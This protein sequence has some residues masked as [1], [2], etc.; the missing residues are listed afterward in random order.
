MRTRR[1]VLAP[2]R[3]SATISAWRSP[4]APPR[5]FSDAH[6]DRRGEDPRAD[7]RGA[8]RRHDGA[9]R[10]D[11]GRRLL[12]L[13]V[14][15]RL[16]HPGGRGRPRAR[17]RGRQRSSSIRSASRTSRARR[18]TSSTG[19]RSPASRSTTR[20]PRRRAAAGTPSRW[21]R[22]PRMPRTRTSAAAAPAAPTEL[23][24]ARA[25]PFH[26]AGAEPAAHHRG[27]DRKGARHPV[28]CRCTPR[29]RIQRSLSW[30]GGLRAS[31]SCGGRGLGAGGVLRGGRAARERGADRRG[32]PVRPAADAVGARAARRRS[33]PSEHQ[34]RL[35]GLRADRAAAGFPVLRQRRGRPRSRPRRA[36]APLRRRRLRGR[37]AD[38]PADGHS[39]RGSAGLV[40][41]DGVRRLVQRPP[42]FPRTSRS[43]SPPSG[44]S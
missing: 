44:R 2:A 22:A 17:A 15:P 29:G 14:R 37:R 3:A 32:G 10:R 20:T 38:R 31:L 21:K 25:A 12:G 6:A 8:R 7:G 1:P 16:R 27:H 40:A 13:P 34:G 43:T 23:G 41:G 30:A 26:A 9:A 11:P 4:S 19:C 35:A 42:G 36:D 24:E 5:R 28:A 39:R 18:S 33:R